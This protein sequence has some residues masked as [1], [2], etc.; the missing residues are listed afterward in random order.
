MEQFV[1][2]STTCLKIFRR[3]LQ[4]IF[5][6]GI[7]VKVHKSRLLQDNRKLARESLIT[8]LDNLYNG[9]KSIEN[10]KKAILLEK[11]KQKKYRQQKLSELKKKWKEQQKLE[12]LDEER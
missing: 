5:F 12:N 4:L 10:Q 8:K 1:R 11:A 9:E 2:D 6:L 7:V 3:N